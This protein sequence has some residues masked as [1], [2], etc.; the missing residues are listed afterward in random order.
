MMLVVFYWFSF[1]MPLQR[2]KKVEILPSSSSFPPPTLPAYAWLPFS[3]WAGVVVADVTYS[4]CVW[5]MLPLYDFDFV[6]FG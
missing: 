6:V 4:I 1:G 5:S 3:P 2:Q